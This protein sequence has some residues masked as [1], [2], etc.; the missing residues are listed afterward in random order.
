MPSTPLSV[1]DVDA[2]ADEE[3]T[4]SQIGE[5]KNDLT[6]PLS[7]VAEATR[8]G[9]PPD[10]SAPPPLPPAR[11]ALGGPGTGKAAF[12]PGPPPQQPPAPNATRGSSPS[13]S[14]FAGSTTSPS[15]G[16]AAPARPAA[17]SAPSS[18]RLAAAAPL[19]VKPPPPVKPRAATMLG[20]GGAPAFGA[21]PAPP[22]IAK[23]G[24]PFV[25]PPPAELALSLEISPPLHDEVSP[26]AGRPANTEP[27]PPPEPGTAAAV[28][29]V[30]GSSP[31][32]DVPLTRHCTACQGRYPSD[33]LVC[34]RDAT[35]L[36]DETEQEKPDPLVGK[37]LGETYQ[38][39]R[40]VGEGGM[41]RIYEARHLR[42]KERRFAV[43]TLHAEMAKTPEI[44]QRF[45]REA[46][47]ASSINHPNVVDVFDVH[48]LPDGTP[49]FVG[50]FLEGEEL[51]DYVARR[52]AL[53][54]RMATAVGR[55]ICAALVAAHARGIV[56]RDI[57]PENIFVTKA[58]IDA[59]ASGEIATVEVKILDFGISKTGDVESTHLTRTG[60]IMGTPS[61]MAPEQ[62][63]GKK[64][65]HRADIYSLGAV[66]YY[67]L[68]GHRPFDS[69]DPS[70]ILSM[71]LTQDPVRLRE[72]DGRIPEGLELVVQRAMAKDP[73]DR[74]QTMVEL[75]KALAA[76]A[77]AG[78]PIPSSPILDLRPALESKSKTAFDLA[79]AV[80]GVTS[81]PP[82]SAN[83]AKSA[84]PTIT[85]MSIVL[86]L[87]LIGGTTAALSGLVR[88]LHDGEI[89]ATE[90]GL[91]VIGCLFA[92]ATPAGLYI[93]HVRK[94]IWPNSVRALQLATDLKRTASAA[95]VTYGGVSIVARI[96][97][98]VVWRSSKGLSSGFWD[99]LLF[100]LSIA[101]AATIG[102]LGPLLRNLRRRR[103]S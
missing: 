80:I 50:E 42:L 33:F 90:C 32:I 60:M 23:K 43:K 38:I 36:V 76:F 54:P 78:I 69:E 35:P 47:T 27:A 83:L 37:L 98:T 68:T 100:V 57:K 58:S 25:P 97:H 56:H 72:I 55:Q 10:A 66:L 20:A 34:P 81:V 91:L 28:A 7:G 53:S 14:S 19:A 8:E 29:V 102:G 17:G 18:N 88:V 40:F 75:D 1:P 45:L 11:S 95:L 9:T 79:R 70:A 85:A 5:T 96:G 93:A 41:G 62:A 87:W 52:G 89:T 46:E 4:P 2:K 39:S 94:V 48:H 16:A 6:E 86:G 92:A 59:V 61:Y 74:Y 77:D 30:I 82:P 73:R 44:V 64:V 3:R 65:D 71:V 49:Y 13:N 101:A 24:P 15:G 22:A 63:R 51:A 31:G 67:A 84:R 21:A 99:I 12:R 103:S 26:S